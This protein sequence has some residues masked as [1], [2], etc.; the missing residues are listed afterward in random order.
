MFVILKRGDRF[1][2]RT[3]DTNSE[4]RIR[5]NGIHRYPVTEKWKIEAGWEEYKKPKKVKLATAIPSYTEEY[6]VPG[7]A[8]LNING[9]QFR[10]E[11]IVEEGS[12]QLFFV[13]LDD[14]NALDTY[15]EGRYLYSSPPEKGIV[16]LD[17]NKAINPPSAFSPFAT[18]PLAPDSNRLKLKIESG[19]KR[20][21]S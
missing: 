17:F 10:L 8:I 6:A 21:Q 2:L 16:L 12:D 14:T 7:V 19:E 13:F 5:F 15:S 3:W 20:Y 18:S 11:P 9:I 1:A 4:S